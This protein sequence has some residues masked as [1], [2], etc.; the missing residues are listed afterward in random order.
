MDSSK[1]SKKMF[2]LIFKR[3]RTSVKMKMDAAVCLPKCYNGVTEALNYMLGITYRMI[4]ENCS[5]G[6]KWCS[7]ALLYS[8]VV[9][10]DAQ[11]RRIVTLFYGLRFM[12]YIGVEATYCNALIASPTAYN[13]VGAAVYAVICSKNYVLYCMNWYFEVQ[14]HC[15]T[16]CCFCNVH[17]AR[18]RSKLQFVKKNCNW[19]LICIVICEITTLY[20]CLSTT[21]SKVLEY[22]DCGFSKE[23]QLRSL[24]LFC[25]RSYKQI[26]LIVSAL[27]Y[28]YYKMFYLIMQLR[29]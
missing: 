21:R 18:K 9:L 25:R 3:T 28:W 5:Y 26:W 13:V 16:I 10:P 24:L 17:A 29:L 11:F 4:A 7:N 12:H 6:I 23:V 2:L 27:Q 19:T 14:I 1:L 15:S 8:A 22:L 20:Y